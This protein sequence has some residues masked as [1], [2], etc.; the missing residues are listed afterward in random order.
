MERE[1]GNLIFCENF[2]SSSKDTRYKS[3]NNYFVSKQ[4]V[5]LQWK[6]AKTSK[7]K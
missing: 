1:I 2:D 6:P 7:Y 5:V 3:D 4:E